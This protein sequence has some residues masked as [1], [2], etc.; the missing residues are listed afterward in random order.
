MTTT[1]NI[2]LRQD[3][4]R[5]CEITESL[6]EKA[7]KAGQKVQ[8]RDFSWATDYAEPGYSS[9]A[10]GIVFGDWNPAIFGF[11]RPRSEQKRDPVC[12]LARILEAS[13]CEC[14]WSDEWATCS[15]CGKAI[16]TSPDCHQWFPYYRLI[17]GC[18]IVCLDCIDPESYLASIEDDSDHAVPS[19]SRFD[20]L[21]FGYQKY[22]G[23]FETGFHPGQTDSPKEVLAKM[24]KLGLSRIVLRLADKGQFDITWQPFHNPNPK[25]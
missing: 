17:D 8:S 20:P 11:D 21:L 7:R 13:G 1:N 14:E 19:Y 3:I 12:K 9:P 24:Q 25:E 15:D 2:P 5:L 18:E 6:I 23:N 16:L 4:A 22:N 10:H